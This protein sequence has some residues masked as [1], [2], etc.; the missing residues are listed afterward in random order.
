VQTRNG[1]ASTTDG[2]LAEAKGELGGFFLIDARDLAAAS[3]GASK[4]PSARRRS[5]E[6]RSIWALKQ[7]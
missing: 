3:H 7:P 4:L 6:V 2:P 5:V 1:R